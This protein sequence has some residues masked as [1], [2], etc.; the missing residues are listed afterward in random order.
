MH[1]C[2]VELEAVGEAIRRFE[3]LPHRRQTIATIRGVR[4]VDDSKATNLA[5]VQGALD[6]AT[7]G[8]RLIAGGQLKETDLE[9]IKQVLASKVRG[10]YLIGEAAGRMSAAWGG[11]VPCRECGTLERAVRAAWLDAQRGEE[12]LLSTGC[13]SFDQF[14]SYEERGECF[15]R[16]VKAIS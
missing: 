11:V 6:M 5:A 15:S 4:F 1:A 12:V 10:A 14:K 13:A 9:E 3:P 2:G 7:G 8:V 16:L